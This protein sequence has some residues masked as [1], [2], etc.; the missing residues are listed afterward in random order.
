LAGSKSR[1][2]DIIDGLRLWRIWLK[3]S[4][5]DVRQ[6]YS[7]SVIGPFWATIG[8]AVTVVGI[9]GVFSLLWNIETRSLIPHIATGLILWT[10]IS[11]VVNEGTSVFA[12]NA[13]I[14]KSVKLPMSLHAYR[15]ISKNFIVAAHHL[16]IYVAVILIY[17]LPIGHLTLLAIP[18]LLLYALNAGW[19]VLFLGVICTRY[20]DIPQVVQNLTMLLF[21]ISPVFWFSETLGEGRVQLIV[22]FNILAHFLDLVRLPMLGKAPAMGTWIVVI[23]FTLVGW[24]ITLPFFERYRKRTPNWL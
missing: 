11:Q 9:G 6:R 17:D 21:F 4:W 12:S 10:F 23:V 3:W 18:G 24:A 14:I 13:Q 19:I 15:L 5:S 8:L 1:T 16:L 7:R 20:R 2:I 22:K